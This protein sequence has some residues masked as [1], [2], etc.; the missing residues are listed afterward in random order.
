MNDIDIHQLTEQLHS[1]ASTKR[2]SAAKKLRKLKAKDAGPAL[3]ETLKS[4]LKD[5]RTWETQYHM[6]M[7]LGESGY[8]DSLNFLQQIAKQDFEAT[9]VLTAIGDAVT[10]LERLKNHKLTSLGKWIDTNNQA[11]IEGG[12][13]TLATNQLI[14]DEILIRKIISYAQ[15]SGGGNVDFWAAAASPSWPTQL[16]KKFLEH[17]LEYSLLDDT[18]KAAEAALKGK[19]LK[20]QPL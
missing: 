16:T 11:L 9:M 19:Y 14:P 4:E 10:N 8:T 3:L 1:K 7:A 12:I 2:R 15:K 18:K 5:K 6:I 17:C 20:W 13:R